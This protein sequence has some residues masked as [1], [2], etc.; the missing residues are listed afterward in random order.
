MR[1]VKN[2]GIYEAIGDAYTLGLKKTFIV[3]EFFKSLFSPRYFARIVYRGLH[4]I[5]GYFRGPYHRHSVPVVPPRPIYRYSYVHPRDY[6]KKLRERAE[7]W[8]HDVKLRAELE[9]IMR[10]IEDILERE[11]D[12]EQ[13]NWKIL[14]LSH[15]RIQRTTRF[16]PFFYPPMVAQVELSEHPKIMQDLLL[17]YKE[18]TVREEALAAI[19]EAR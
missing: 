13:A 17:N 5:F 6:L 7:R 19:K 1:L 3:K 16:P 14:K 15:E 2:I 12:H 8:K 9:S 11:G 4:S 10:E 18:Y